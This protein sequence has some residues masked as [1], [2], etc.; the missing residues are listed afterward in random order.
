[1]NN[2]ENIP[3]QESIMGIKLLPFD[4]EFFE[5]IEDQNLMAYQDDGKYHTILVNGEKAG[6]VGFL[7]SRRS[8]EEGFVQ[9]VLI[10]SF[11]GRGLVK[12][13]EDLLARQYGF[14]RLYATIVKDNLP[15]IS[16][17]LKCGF[18]MVNEAEMEKLK[19]GG[20]LEENEIRL[21]KEY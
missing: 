6:I 7:P 11:R 8:E 9:I 18:Q 13:A 4:K 2:A 20:F 14:K 21:V 19:K 17:H 16:S 10:K 15:S 3:N 1:M 12:T 5:S